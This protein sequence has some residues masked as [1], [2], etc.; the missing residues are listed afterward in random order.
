MEPE[1]R[2]RTSSLSTPHRC[3]IDMRLKITIVIVT[4][5]NLI[6]DLRRKMLMMTILTNQGGGRVS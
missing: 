6:L 2:K 3:A 1:A 4:I 5:F